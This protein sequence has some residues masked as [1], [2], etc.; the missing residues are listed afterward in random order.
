M[1]RLLEPPIDLARQTDAAH[2]LASAAGM[3]GF[4]ALSTASR[5]FERAVAR[6]A[7]EADG[8][9]EQLRVEI[10]AAL[11]ELDALRN[12]GRAAQRT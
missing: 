9:A 3:L 12:G 1:L 8:M 11:T 10:G 7:P 6:H 2:S 4:A 5:G